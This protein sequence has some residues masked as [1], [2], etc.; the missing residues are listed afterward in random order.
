MCPR[1]CTILT[2][3]TKRGNQI[4]CLCMELAA[5][6]VTTVHVCVW[7]FVNVNPLGT[8]KETSEQIPDMFA[9]IKNCYC[10]QEVWLRNRTFLTR[11]QNICRH[12]WSNQN[13]Y[14]T[15]KTGC[16]PCVL[17]AL[18][19]PELKHTHSTFILPTGLP[20]SHHWNVF[21]LLYWDISHCTLIQ[22]QI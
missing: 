5:K 8:F 3:S 21:C 13:R 16:F 19:Q 10:R 11:P 20:K 6:P 17:F 18:N 2:T 12:V 14:F 15:P 9:A 22:T 1:L 4:T 7:T